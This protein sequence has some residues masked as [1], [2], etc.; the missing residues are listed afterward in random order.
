[1]K[2]R[3]PILFALLL[4]FTTGAFAQPAN[5]LCQNAIAFPAL[6]LGNQV[7]ITGTNNGANPE[8]P[9]ISQGS[10][11]P[12]GTTSMASP[13]SDVWY[14]FVAVGNELVINMT[15]TTFQGANVAVYQGTCGSMLGLGCY[16]SNGANVANANFAPL[17]P[18][19]TYFI[20]VSG[21]T[22]ADS[23]NFN[24]CITN[25][26]NTSICLSNI[27]AAITPQPVAGAYSP[28]DTIDFCYSVNGYTQQGA[29]WFHGLGLSFG[30]GWITPPIN[31]VPATSCDGQGN[32]AWYTSCT[33]SATGQ[34]VGNGFY[35]D[36]NSGGPLDGNPGNNYGDN[37]TTCTWTFC[38]TLVVDPNAA[39]GADLSVD[40][41]HYGDG[42]TGSWSSFSCTADPV[43]HFDATVNPCPYPNYSATPTC[44]GAST[45]TATVLGGGVPPF[46][47]LW[48]NGATTP[49]VSGLP[50]GPIN[51]TVT[52]S[53]GCINPLTV[54]VPEHP[55]M[56]VTALTNPSTCN[57]PTGDITISV[58]GGTP[59][60]NYLWATGEI[61]SYLLNLTPGTYQV[62]VTDTNGCIDSLSTNV[63][64]QGGITATI[65]SSIDVSCNGG[66]DGEATV[67][68]SGSPG[69]YTYQWYTNNYSAISGATSTTVT[70]LS[71]GTYHVIASTGGCDDTATV[72]INE[73]PA[74]TVQATSTDA[75]CFRLNDGTATAI[76]TGGDGN[77]TYLWTPGSQITPTATNLFAGTYT[78]EVLDGNGCSATTT[79]SLSEPPQLIAD[80][81]IDQTFCYGSGGVTL[82][83]SATGG[84]PGYTYSW[85]CA[86]PPCDLSSSTAQN[87]NANPFST[88]TYFLTVTDANGCT[89]A[90]SSTIV[91]VIY[92]PV[93]NLGPDT[94]MCTGQQLGLDAENPG[95]TYAWSTGQ[96]N[97]KITVDA[98]GTYSVTATY[99]AGTAQCSASD[100]IK[101]DYLEQPEVDLGGDVHLCKGESHTFDAGNPGRNYLWNNGIR[102]QTNEVWESGFY[103]VTVSNGHCTDNARARVYVHPKPTFHFPNEPQEFCRQDGIESFLEGPSGSGYQYLWSTG[104]IFQNIRPWE[105]GTYS[106]TVISPYGC[107]YTDSMELIQNCQLRLFIPT[108]FTPNGDGLNDEF[109]IMGGLI[110]DFSMLVMDRWGKEMFQTN[111]INNSWN[112]TVKGGQPAPTGVYTYV[113]KYRGLIG[114]EEKADQRAGTITLIR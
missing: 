7:C 3:N 76:V 86:T 92:M 31:L 70:G 45:G 83:G 21:A 30:A 98:P 4:F 58:L 100:D 10:C 32:W 16:T 11:Q 103:N 22:M 109:T 23:A 97:Q 94:T 55:A 61:T 2:R 38:W 44:N 52:D 59:G 112:G 84:T 73:L 63:I 37:S 74:L 78:V 62:T 8:F 42:Q 111:N 36:S 68:V 91:T 17:T 106:L 18:G 41:T 20:Q 35:Y 60:Y 96:T 67:S 9:Y 66:S 53:N 104:E 39:A 15:S 54:I 14:S 43:W 89:S 85:T 71:A 93:V 107:E 1:M 90:A 28:G 13:S 50:S 77:Y 64:S 56:Q 88:N 40:V 5:D 113:I 114:T 80:A 57:T 72:V 75:S 87:P 46:T 34:T 27:S 29:N 48:A 33:S 6:V 105:A 65:A 24:L 49:S 79:V 19:A 108:G 82:N 101:V 12:N 25:N 47:Y 102:G 69:P 51:V 110:T 26:Q 99:S 95:A 81:G